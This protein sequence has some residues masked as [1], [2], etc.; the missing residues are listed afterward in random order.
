MGAEAFTKARAYLTARNIETLDFPKFLELYA[1]YC[2][3]TADSY[4]Q[5]SAREGIVPH[6]VPSSHGLW[7]EV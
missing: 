3:L 7:I 5:V 6:W 2:G 4:S 1:T